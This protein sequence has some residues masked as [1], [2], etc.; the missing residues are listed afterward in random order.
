MSLLA[1][2][3]DTEKGWVLA[4]EMIGLTI[5]KLLKYIDSTEI[6]I[7]EYSSHGVFKQFLAQ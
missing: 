6:S 3:Y 7:A 2:I 1:L 5:G 4:N